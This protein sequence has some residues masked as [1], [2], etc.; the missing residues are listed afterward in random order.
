VTDEVLQR[1]AA[2]NAGRLTSLKVV[3][4]RNITDAG[5]CAAIRA[6]PQLRQFVLEDAGQGVTGAFVPALLQHCRQL[7]SLAIEGAERISWALL[8]Q[9]GTWAAEAAAGLPP[10]P[11]QQ[12]ASTSASCSTLSRAVRAAQSARTAA[13]AAAGAGGT[14]SAARALLQLQQDQ[15]QQQ[16]QGEANGEL[17]RHSR[18]LSSS[19]SI[20]GGVE[21]A[22]SDS[23]GSSSSLGAASDST[24]ISVPAAAV[25]EL[26]LQLR[27]ASLSG[28]AGVPSSSSSPWHQAAAAGQPA[29]E[30]Q[31]RARH[32]A[33]AGSPP[34]SSS[35][36]AGVL[37]RRP[38][39][40]LRRLRVRF[41]TSEGLA[42]LL[43]FAPAATELSLDGPAAVV[44]AAVA[45]CPS[46]RRLTYLVS[47]PAELD[48]A[49]LCLAGAR[50]LEALELEVKAMVLSPAQLGVSCIARACG[51]GC[52]WGMAAAWR[53]LHR[54]CVLHV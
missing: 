34:S 27:D 6:S 21:P 18:R 12:G 33:A 47:S 24:S 39:S 50:S 43:A 17:Y 10:Q 51:C 42:Q 54:G 9:P 49:L 16:D 3:G 37:G 32:L 53:L 29:V 46:L 45:L 35:S 25:S 44:R 36:S 20:S 15:H 19:S 22:E 28:E 38:H 41:T 30:A 8:R 4:A 1:V 48:A 26:T 14:S 40:A 31:A 7:E 13:H 5:L 52:V 11:Q 2:T 23:G